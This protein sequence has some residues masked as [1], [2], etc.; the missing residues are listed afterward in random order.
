LEMRRNHIT[1]EAWQ[2]VMAKE[3]RHREPVCLHGKTAPVRTTVGID[4]RNSP[5]DLLWKSH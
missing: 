3:S 4:L 2:D 5:Q 1:A